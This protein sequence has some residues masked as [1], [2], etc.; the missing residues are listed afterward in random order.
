M[1]NGIQNLFHIFF[2]LKNELYNQKM[3]HLINF[4]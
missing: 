2:L 1:L 3:G 4:N